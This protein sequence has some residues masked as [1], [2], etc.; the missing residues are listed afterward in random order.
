MLQKRYEDI[1][2][3]AVPQMLSW[4]M[5]SSVGYDSHVTVAVDDS[6]ELI[7]LPSPSCDIVLTCFARLHAFDYVHAC[8]I[9]VTR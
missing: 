1:H 2:Q 8:Y 3:R 7:G 4:R 5:S 9:I 6:A